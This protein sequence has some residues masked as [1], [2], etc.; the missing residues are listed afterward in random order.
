MTKYELLETL[1]QCI[2]HCEAVVDHDI[3]ERLKATMGEQHQ[4]WADDVEE[5]E[6]PLLSVADC[7]KILDHKS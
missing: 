1:T 2:E 5:A 3:A 4:R 7:L 6:D